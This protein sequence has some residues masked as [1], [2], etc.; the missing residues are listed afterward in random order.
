[1]GCVWA[2]CSECVQ[3]N[4]KL[5]SSFFLKLEFWL[6]KVVPYVEISMDPI[7]QYISNFSVPKRRL[8]NLIKMQIL[9]LEVWG[10]AGNSIS[11]MT[12][13]ILALGPHIE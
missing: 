1:M 9:I 7:K 2:R 10:G 13:M 8:G 5:E 3:G 12:S 4:S 6:V 11:Q